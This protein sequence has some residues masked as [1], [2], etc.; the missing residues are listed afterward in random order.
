MSGLSFRTPRSL[1]AIALS[2]VALTT[3]AAPACA[4]FTEIQPGARVR[5]SAPGIVAGRYVGTVLTRSADTVELGAPGTA[6]IK[7]PFARLTSVEVSR[8]SS[9]MLGA[10]RGVMWGAPIGLI[11][12]VVAASGTD[13]DPYC[14]DSCSTSGSYKAG[15][16]AAST[17]AGALWG[18]GIGA[19]VGRERWER[20]EL[21]PHTSFDT[22]RGRAA[23]GFAVAF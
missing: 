11:I 15:I 17:V 19:I 13:G 22:R 7:V 9:R 16:V 18:A 23:L 5:I 20:F 3:T 12:G 2:L 4:Q 10:G 1:S 8:G 14:Y 6:P 21:T